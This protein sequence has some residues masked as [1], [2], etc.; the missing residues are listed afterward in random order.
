MFLG[1][2]MFGVGEGV[3]REDSTLVLCCG[4]LFLFCFVFSSLNADNEFIM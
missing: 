4:V 1:V 3:G 2:C